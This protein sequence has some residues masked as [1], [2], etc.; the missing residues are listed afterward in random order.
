M[1]VVGDWSEEDDALDDA[2]GMERSEGLEAREEVLSEEEEEGAL[3][4]G[5]D[6]FIKVMVSECEG[7]IGGT[8][9]SRKRAE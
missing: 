7:R 1:G 4:E 9:R 3:L 8:R 2:V 5:E 6:I